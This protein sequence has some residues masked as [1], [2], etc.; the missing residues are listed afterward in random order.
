MQQ[1]KPST[2]NIRGIGGG[3]MDI[4]EVHNLIH[5]QPG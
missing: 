5:G 2:I 3:G 1:L 4:S